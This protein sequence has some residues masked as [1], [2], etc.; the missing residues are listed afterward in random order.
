MDRF[1]RYVYWGVLLAIQVTLLVGGDGLSHSLRELLGFMTSMMLLAVV[2]LIGLGRDPLS[3]RKRIS[4]DPG[5][6]DV[7][8]AERSTTIGIRLTYD[9]PPQPL[10]FQCRR[11]HCC[12]GRH[13]LS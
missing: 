3:F 13:G 7:L 11:R 10:A 5:D 4:Y 1:F 9:T 2:V 6:R 8:I 12:D